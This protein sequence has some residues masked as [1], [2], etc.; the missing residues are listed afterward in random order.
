M[1]LRHLVLQGRLDEAAETLETLPP[2][3]G[4]HSLVHVLS[5]EL[6]RRRGNLSLAADAYSRAIGSDLGVASPFRC[7][8]CRRPADSWK[9]YCEE[10]RRW[11]TY[12]GRAD[13]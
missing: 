7:A 1:L 5:A 2:P 8:V 10:C 9:G 13:R 6:H 11:G 3:V 12:Q 4:G